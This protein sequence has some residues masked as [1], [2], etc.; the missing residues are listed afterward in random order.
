[1]RKTKTE[2]LAD[3]ETYS[4]WSDALPLKSVL[5]SLT[6]KDLRAIEFEEIQKWHLEQALKR[7]AERAALPFWRR[8][9][10]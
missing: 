7:Q 2:L 8:I 3:I 9:F 6:Q 5:I 4:T 1:M 10:A